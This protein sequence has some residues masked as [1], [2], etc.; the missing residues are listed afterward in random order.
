[1]I[2]NEKIETALKR[3]QVFHPF[4][5]FMCAE[6]K[7]RETRDFETMATDGDCLLFNPDYVQSL[8]IP[9]VEAVLLHEFHHVIFMHPWLSEKALLAGRNKVIWD[10][11]M[12]FVVNEHVTRL[13]RQ[14]EDFAGASA[15]REFVPKLPGLP[16]CLADVLNHAQDPKPVKDIYFYDRSV[17]CRDVFSAYDYIKESIGKAL[18][19]PTGKKIVQV[20][21]DVRRL[22]HWLISERELE[23]L[24]QKH[25]RGNEVAARK[26][27]ERFFLAPTVFGPTWK[28]IYGNFSHDLRKQFDELTKPEINWKRYLST[29]AGRIVDTDEFR[30]DAPNLRHPMARDVIYPG[31]RTEKVEDVYIAIDTSG[32]IDARM[33]SQFLSECAGILRYLERVGI[34]TIDCVERPIQFVEPRELQKLEITGGGG[35]DFRAAFRVLESQ[36]ITPA[37]LIYFTDGFGDFPEKKPHFPVLWVLTSHSG[38]VPEGY[39]RVARFSTI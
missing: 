1:M 39:G 18:R 13:I 4:F 19:R 27:R 10:L 12:E 6:L 34:M 33:L 3:I 24:I 23:R 36:K 9:E 11:A 28:S 15:N 20:S 30:F 7:I 37:V 22:D 29:I 26:V 5:Y 21:G 32:S 16:F 8:S 35:T 31:L 25:L 2:R 14:R 17:G 38:E